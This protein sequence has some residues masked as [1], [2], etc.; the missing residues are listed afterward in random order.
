MS[1]FTGL[2]WA[3]A[4]ACVLASAVTIWGVWRI[5]QA[6]VLRSPEIASDG[7]DDEAQR[8]RHAEAMESRVEQIKGRSMFFIPP[9]PPR[10]APPRPAPPPVVDPG[11]PPP[12][13]P[14]S[15]YGGPSILGIASD[16]VWFNDGK[17]RTIGD[18]EV[19]GVRVLAVNPPWDVRVRWRNAEFTVSLFDRDK[20]VYP[21]KPADTKPADPK[22]AD[23]P[24]PGASP[25]PEPPASPASES[26]GATNGTPDLPKPPAPTDPS[27]PEKPP[28]EP[29]GPAP[30]NESTTDTPPMPPTSPPAE[31]PTR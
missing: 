31:D 28:A 15:T 7:P 13:P 5:G 18:E 12:P 6:S 26:S 2:S 11:P 22:P 20:V 30:A 3:A 19:D 29:G 17:P 8:K 10:P 21:A 27:G 4:G 23:D 16:R 25:T 1:A 9:P 14:P 24:A